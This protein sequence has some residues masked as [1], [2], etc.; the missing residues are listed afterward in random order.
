MG[1]HLVCRADDVP[2]DRGLI[3]EVAG[4]EL[5]IF[6]H[7]DE[8]FA[9][10]NLCPHQRG[11]VAEGGVFPALRARHEPGKIEGV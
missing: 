8:F 11:P 10:R 1:E 5:G 7:G 6:R 9:L 2:D 4:R 3:V